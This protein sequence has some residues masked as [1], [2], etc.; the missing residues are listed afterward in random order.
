MEEENKVAVSEN[1]S[2][3]DKNK[4]QDIADID[5]SVL[6]N[7][8]LQNAV[9]EVQKNGEG[10]FI[11]IYFEQGKEFCEI[12]IINSLSQESRMKTDILISEKE[13]I[14]NHGFGLKNVNEV[15]K[16]CNGKINFL[17][18]E[19]RFTVVVLLRNYIKVNAP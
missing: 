2:S 16:K 9:E 3:N 19:D 12:R 15:I 8:L 13:D 6:Y 5:I 11:E 14:R 10:K 7:N 1:T 17:R 18:E 4:N